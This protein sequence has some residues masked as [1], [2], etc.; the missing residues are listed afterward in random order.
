MAQVHCAE[1]ELDSFVSKLKSL[2]QLGMS[3]T[4]NIDV[5]GGKASIVMK[6]DLGFVPPPLRN[7]RKR[8]PAYSRRQERR[9][10]AV[11]AG[12]SNSTDT[13]TAESPAATHGTEDNCVVTEQVTDC[14]TDDVTEFRQKISD[15]ENELRSQIKELLKEIQEKNEVI[16]VNNMLHD[17][18]KERV[19]EK[20]FYSSADEDEISDYEPDET[21]R[22][23]LRQEFMRRKM[24]KRRNLTQKIAILLQKVSQV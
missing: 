8:G 4:L 12:V 13:A 2:W 21:R 14:P 24:E 5:A 11:N 6:A 23:L 19:K 10:Q 17:D 20:Y 7:Q 9:R 3:A 15:T 16:A 22:I 18:F 1:V